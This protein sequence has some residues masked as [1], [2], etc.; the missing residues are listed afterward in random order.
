MQYAL[1]IR[2]AAEDFARRNDPA[3]RD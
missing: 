2:E 1:I 3:Y